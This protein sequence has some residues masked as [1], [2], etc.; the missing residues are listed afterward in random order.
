ME[1]PLNCSKKMI[2]SGRTILFFAVF[3]GF[4]SC[5]PVTGRN[6]KPASKQYE[7]NIQWKLDTYAAPSTSYSTQDG[8]YLYFIEIYK[9]SEGK[10]CYGIAKVDL[11]NG[12]QI[13]SSEPFAVIDNRIGFNRCPQVCGDYLF[14][15][16]GA[17]NLIYCYDVETGELK[18]EY[19]SNDMQGT[20][21]EALYILDDSKNN[22]T[23]RLYC[24]EHKMR[25]CLHR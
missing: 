23:D 4:C 25:K 15:Q 7:M 19:E 13:W 18:W 3:C 12:T 16:D 5:K 22:L 8:H 11:E 20:G 21:L 6:D 14:L 2:F 24:F 1:N 10:F 17:G 9:N